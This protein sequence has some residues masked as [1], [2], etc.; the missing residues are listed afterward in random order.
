MHI[1][2]RTTAINLKYANSIVVHQNG[3]RPK[4]LKLVSMTYTPHV[5]DV[6]TTDTL[7]LVLNNRTTSVLTVLSDLNHQ[8]DI[9]SIKDTDDVSIL[10][11]NVS[12][13]R[14]SSLTYGEFNGIVHVTIDYYE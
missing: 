12:V 6:S 11:C 7:G 1:I 9:V 10:V 13:S 5:L 2:T 14:H 3:R 4:Q 8:T